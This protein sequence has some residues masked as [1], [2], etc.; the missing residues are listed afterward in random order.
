MYRVYK[1]TN[2]TNGKVYIGITKNTL[3]QRYQEGYQK[4]AYFWNAL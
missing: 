4:C 2:K 1:Y 3:S